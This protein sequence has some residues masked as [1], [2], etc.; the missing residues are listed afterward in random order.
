MKIKMSKK[1][2]RSVNTCKMSRNCLLFTSYMSRRNI[3]SVIGL[4]AILF[5]VWIFT[6]SEEENEEFTERVK[7]SFREV[8]HQL[9]LSGQDTTSLVLPVIELERSKYELLFEKELSFLP[10]DLVTIVKNSLEKAE[11]PKNYRVEVIQC[12]DLE[13]AYSYEIK[14]DKEKNIIPCA[15]RLLPKNCY[16]ISIQFSNKESHFGLMSF[17]YSLIFIAF[18]AVLFYKSKPNAK[19]KQTDSN[20]FVPIGIFQFYRDQNKLIKATEEISL[21]RK[22]CELLAIFI[23]SPNQIIKRDELMKKVWEDHGVI[24]GRSLDTY[25]SKLRKKLKDDDSIK[26]TNVHGVGYKL[27][28]I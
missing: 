18:I 16:T 2:K 28:I 24:V 12:A 25:I 14:N 19:I 3:Y 21:S 27:E 7:I 15:G 8:G 5:S 13:V 23:D 17:I 10:N 1:C 26:I 4:I 11:L 6:D 22:E 9:L 20:T